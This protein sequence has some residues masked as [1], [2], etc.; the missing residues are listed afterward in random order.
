MFHKCNNV[1]FKKLL[2]MQSTL[3]TELFASLVKSKRGKKG[4]RDA[5]VEIDV[6]AATLSR[7]EQG[8]LPDVE[9][10]IRICKWLEVPTDTFI[11]GDKLPLSNVSEKERLVYQLRS[12]RELDP[13]TIDAMVK[14]V[15]IAFTTVRKNG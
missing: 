8:K 9:T 3:N 4:L 5:A 13:D 7:V 1:F 12:S 15:D 14:M 6:S 11:I 10:F 2:H